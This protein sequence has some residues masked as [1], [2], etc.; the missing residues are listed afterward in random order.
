MSAPASSIIIEAVARLQEAFE[1]AGLRVPVALVLAGE[2]QKQL[3]EYVFSRDLG[4]MMREN[5][6][7]AWEGTTIRGMKVIDNVPN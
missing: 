5:A 2:E 3:L 1:N 7:G 6:A 4:Y